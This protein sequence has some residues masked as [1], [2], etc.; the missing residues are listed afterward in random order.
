MA[1]LQKYPDDMVLGDGA[2]A[3]LSSNYVAEPEIS[4]D[5]G[6]GTRTGTTTEDAAPK[7]ATRMG[8]GPGGSP[9]GFDDAYRMLNAPQGPT[10]IGQVAQAVNLGE[11]SGQEQ[12]ARFQ[13][14]A[15]PDIEYG[16]RERGIVNRA[17]SEG[18]TE[19]DEKSSYEEARE[20]IN[21]TYSGPRG[22][23]IAPEDDMEPHEYMEA[24]GTTR[25]ARAAAEAFGEAGTTAAM[26][27]DL[28]P[29]Q[30]RR[31]AER[32]H[33]QEGF[34]RGAR[35]LAS[36]AGDVHASL[37]DK[38]RQSVEIGDEREEQARA[39]GDLARE[40]LSQ[41]QT[42]IRKD[43]ESTVERK[44]KE[45]LDNSRALDEYVRTGDKDGL[46]GKIAVAELTGLTT[47]GQAYVAWNEVM[48]RQ[49]FAAVKGMDTLQLRTH[50]TG[51]K[52]LSLSPRLQEELRNLY[53]A[54]ERDVWRR[55]GDE[56]G[57]EGRAPGRWLHRLMILAGSDSRTIGTQ[58]R[59]VLPIIRSLYARQQALEVQF[60]PALGNLGASQTSGAG[61]T[62]PDQIRG[63]TLGGGPTLQEAGGGAGGAGGAMFGGGGP[64]YDPALNRSALVDPISESGSWFTNYLRPTQR[65][66]R[67]EFAHLLPLYLGDSRVGMH[68]SLRTG[69]FMTPAEGV[70]DI[71][72]E[73]SGDQAR[74]YNIMERLGGGA[75]ELT[76]GGDPI[77][78]RINIDMERLMEEERE[79]AA[80]GNKALDER[81]TA[82]R[83]SLRESRREFLRQYNESQ[84]DGSF[85]D[86]VFD[87]GQEFLD[88]LGFFDDDEEPSGMLH[89]PRRVPGGIRN[90]PDDQFWEV[91]NEEEE[92]L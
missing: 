91:I 66:D 27:G 44:R 70:P 11:A 14:E 80:G 86:Q 24:R 75:E 77:D 29:G 63:R 69:G 55:M 2:G 54:L 22:M 21:R 79:A 19:Q 85:L 56:A 8:V 43:V 42:G 83:R 51:R 47:R 31:Y 37:E 46:A 32:L 23:G 81:E 62:S 59:A 45:L 71:R 74:R 35:Q 89:S 13:E 50:F 61:I 49:E 5:S 33:G 65:S 12:F 87:V 58:A 82:Y 1:S 16:A 30:S 17:L 18:Q 78:T 67:G 15:G 73:I 76:S 6:G 41:R 38:L 36:R 57:G 9:M 88:P 7:P 84:D 60:S 20:I 4:A 48:N 3:E 34:T 64:S 10:N 52:I 72:S 68:P 53:P 25:D 39:A 40:D 28:T 26:R 90:L 92:E